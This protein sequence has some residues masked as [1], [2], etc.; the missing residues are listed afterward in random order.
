MT[1]RTTPRL[2]QLTS[3]AI[4]STIA[5]ALAAC[6]NG[7]PTIP[8]PTNPTPADLFRGTAGI[9]ITAAAE[10]KCTPKTPAWGFMPPTILT[11]GVISAD[12]NGWIVRLDGGSRF[13]NLQMNLASNGMTQTELKLV[14]S[15]Q[16][17][18]ADLLSTIRFP[19]PDRVTVSGAGGTGSAAVDGTFSTQLGGVTGH[20]TGT[21]AF[22]DNQGGV[23]TCSET[24]LFLY[25][26]TR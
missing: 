3:I 9:T 5:A 26:L 24:L 2:R 4:A 25:V 20:M 13:G 15:A 16:G 11:Q 14:G 7:G 17:T 1:R 21:F 10:D 23:T 12:G 6:D 18:V 8:T 22:T 19:N